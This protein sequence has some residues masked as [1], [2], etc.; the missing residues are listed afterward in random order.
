MIT[1]HDHFIN[2]D[3]AVVQPVDLTPHMD[4]LDILLVIPVAGLPCAQD[5]R[6]VHMPHT[7]TA[8]AQP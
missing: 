2:N 8:F 1:F 3:A 4:S 6:H 5:F 7:E